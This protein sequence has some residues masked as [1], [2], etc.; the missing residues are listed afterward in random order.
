[1]NIPRIAAILAPGTDVN[2]AWLHKL[3]GNP[4]RRISRLGFAAY[5]AKTTRVIPVFELQPTG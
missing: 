4:G 3:R 5:Q 2:L 1:M